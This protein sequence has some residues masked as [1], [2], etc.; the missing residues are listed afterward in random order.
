MYLG[1][2][3]YI[4][5]PKVREWDQEVWWFEPWCSQEKC[6]TAVGPLSKAFNPAL[7]QGGLSPA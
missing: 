2:L 1:S 3:L 5:V 6:C 7:L 4:L